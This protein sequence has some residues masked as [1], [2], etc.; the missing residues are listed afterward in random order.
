MDILEVINKI[1]L[2]LLK[3][4]GRTL[5]G[6]IDLLKDEI[7]HGAVDEEYLERLE[8]DK[9]HLEGLLELIDCLSIALEKL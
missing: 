3:E 9:L 2:E 7:E 8:I 6:M 1:D 5:E 4:Q